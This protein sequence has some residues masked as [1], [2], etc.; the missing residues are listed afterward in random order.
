MAGD[1][2]PATHGASTSHPTTISALSLP[3]IPPQEGDAPLLLTIP[4]AGQLSYPPVALPPPPPPP[5]HMPSGKLVSSLRAN[6]LCD[7][8]CLCW[9]RL[10]LLPLVQTACN[11][12]VGLAL[13]CLPCCI[14]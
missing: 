3:P 11:T 14:Y 5:G 6:L 10:R 13:L 2:P 4:L 12:L 1:I 7:G 9:L 8:V